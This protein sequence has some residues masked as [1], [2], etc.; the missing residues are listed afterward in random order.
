M[1]KNNRTTVR[2]VYK[3]VMN[4]RQLKRFHYNVTQLNSQRELSLLWEQDYFERYAYLHDIAIYITGTKLN[5]KVLPKE[6]KS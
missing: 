2:G 4:D 1:K 3:E 6:L 5:W